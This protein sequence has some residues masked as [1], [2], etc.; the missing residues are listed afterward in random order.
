MDNIDV[1]AATEAGIVVQNTPLGN[2]TSAAEHAVAML[3]AIARNIPR[4][5]ALMNQRQKAYVLGRNAPGIW[6]IALWLRGFEN[7]FCDM[8]ERPAFA[9]ALMDLICDIKMKYWEKALGLLGPVGPALTV[10]VMIVAAVTV[11]WKNGVFAAANGVEMP[12]LYAVAG[13]ALALTGPGRYSLDALLG[14]GTLW[15]PAL[16]AGVLG[17]GILGGLGNLVLRRPAPAAS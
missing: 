3:F 7:F 6:E 9:E 1:E 14:L 16:G 8:I 2:I 11:H 10:S 4:A 5:D 15:T 13:V 17:L 12:L